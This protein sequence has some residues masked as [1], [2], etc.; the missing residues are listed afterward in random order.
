V[1]TRRWHP[2]AARFC[3]P[4]VSCVYHSEAAENQFLQNPGK[5]VLGDGFQARSGRQGLAAP[6]QDATP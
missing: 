6:G 5:S 3:A 2:L 1:K 4:Q